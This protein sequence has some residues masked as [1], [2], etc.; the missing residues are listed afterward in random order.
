[1]QQI[2][3]GEAA[4]RWLEASPKGHTLVLV[5]RN[6]LAQL[7]DL[8]EGRIGESALQLPS[9]VQE[10]RFTPGGSRVLLRTANW[11][12]RAS[13]SVTGLNW[14]DAILAPHVPDRTRIVFG[15]SGTDQKSGPGNRL[16]LPV[17]GSGFVHLT[18]LSFVGAKGPGLF[19]NKE[20]LLGEWRERLGLNDDT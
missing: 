7:F 16:Y 18:Q 9:P 3:Q 8:A 14:I 12:H 13:T 17:V 2:W 20:Q 4:I 15:Q 6:N 5:D 19:G 11:I 1:M 10:V